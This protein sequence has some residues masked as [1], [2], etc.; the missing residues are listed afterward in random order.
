M[1]RKKDDSTNE[2][3]TLVGCD[4]GENRDHDHG[5]VSGGWFKDRYTI[6]PNNPLSAKAIHEWEKAGGRPGQMYRTHTL[7]EFTADKDHFYP[8][9]TLKCWL[10]DELIFEKVFEDKIKRDLV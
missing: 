3:I 9:A 2:T 4:F 5:L 7:S 6:N 1:R 8:K 10:N